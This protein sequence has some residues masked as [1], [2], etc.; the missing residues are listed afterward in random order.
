M[1]KTVPKF[2]SPEEAALFWEHHEILNYVEPDEFKII[3]PR[4]SRSYSFANPKRKLE[5]RL[6]SL[7]IDTR[8]IHKA[9][10]LAASRE[11]GYQSIL[12]NWLEKGAV[13]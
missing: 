9:K 12:R 4:K 1:K 13:R 5:K 8:L 11:V 7:R 2:H 3:H 6:I 10:N